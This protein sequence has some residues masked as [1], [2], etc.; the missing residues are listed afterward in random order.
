MN[1]ALIGCGHM[2]SA[3]AKHLARHYR[4]TIYTRNKEKG[5]K[6]AAETGAI[7]AD[8]PAE[9][10]KDADVVVLAVQPKDL[11][12]LSST[13][14]LS[15]KQVA[16]SVLAG[17]PISR[18]KKSFP[19]ALIVRM[20]PNLAITARKGIIGLC[21]DGTLTIA[22]KAD[23]EK[24]FAGIGL[25][26]WTSEKQMHAFSALAASSPAFVFVMMEAMIDAGIS[27]GFSSEIAEEMVCS[28]FEGCSALLQAKKESPG[29]LK[30]QITSPGGMTI[31]GIRA[32]ESAGIRK[33]VFDAFDASYRRS[34]EMSQE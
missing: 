10:V 27:L 18:L 21:E 11:A 25:L 4:L 3:L 6:V 16:L 20:M 7:W 23:I 28:V 2:G 15:S 30:K 33:A 34:I 12:V 22:K 24:M 32:L 26:L 14:E 1:I 17:I 13:I 19:E 31:A 9:A 8:T 5:Q 29:V